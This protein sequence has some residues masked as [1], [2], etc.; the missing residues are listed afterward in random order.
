MQRRLD[1]ETGVNKLFENVLMSGA[2][3]KFFAGRSTSFCHFSSVFFLTGLIL[4]NLSNKNVSGGFLGM[5]PQKI[6]DNLH[7]YCDGHF[8]AF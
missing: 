8:S 4:S 5:L 3:S 6:S 1:P 2:Y 7:T